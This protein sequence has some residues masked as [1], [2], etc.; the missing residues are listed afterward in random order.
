MLLIWLLNAVLAVG[1]FVSLFTFGEPVT[2]PSTTAAV[3]YWRH[4]NQADV[5]LSRVCMSYVYLST[6]SM[7]HVC[8]VK[9]VQHL[10]LL[11]EISLSHIHTHTHNRS[12][13]LLDSVRDYPSEL[14]PER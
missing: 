3:T 12:T 14:A 1:V 9:H 5:Y 7:S 10:L 4:R 6:V 8:T 2:K 13:A 11:A